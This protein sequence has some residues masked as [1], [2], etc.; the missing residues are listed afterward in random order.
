M[1]GLSAAEA[2]PLDFAIHH[3]D[4]KA[5]LASS[6]GDIFDVMCGLPEAER[7]DPDK[8]VALPCWTQHSGEAQTSSIRLRAHGQS[9]LGYLFPLTAFRSGAGLNDDWALRFGH[10]GFHLITQLEVL[11]KL[12]KPNATKMFRGQQVYL[13]DLLP[14]D[15][16]VVVV[17]KENLAKNDITTEQLR[18]MLLKEGIQVAD[19]LYKSHD[20]ASS[21]WAGLEGNPWRPA[22]NL[23]MLS[24]PVRDEATVFFS[25]IAQSDVDRRGL[26]GFLLAYQVME[27]CIGA[28]F[29]WGVRSL[30]GKDVSSWTMKRR[31]SAIST[32]RYRLNILDGFCLGPGVNRGHFDALAE[33][34]GELLDRTKVP[35][36]ASKSWQ[37]QLYKLRNLLVHDHVKLIKAHDFKLD[38]VNR[39]LRDACFELLFHFKEPDF[40]ACWAKA[41]QADDEDVAA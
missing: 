30:A 36:P 37:S 23:A 20:V 4:G 12:A 34:C 10:V 35:K 17:G 2:E 14:E 27:F 29:S 24:E 1:F 3:Q 18:L 26:G 8:Y 38:D 28:I 41:E 33:K 32:E 21:S 25:L 13:D 19:N 39:L 16:G 22:I 11:G 40:D 15:M 9:T 7:R 5:A 31:L 6:L